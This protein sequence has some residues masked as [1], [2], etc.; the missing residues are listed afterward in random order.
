MQND[1]NQPNT[2]LLC[3]LKIVINQYRLKWIYDSIFVFMINSRFVYFNFFL[4]VLGASI[5]MYGRTIW[6]KYK[7]LGAIWKQ[8]ERKEEFLFPI[9]VHLFLVWTIL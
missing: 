5:I 3:C 9:L 4:G 1:Q 7:Q 8:L 6:R 2:A